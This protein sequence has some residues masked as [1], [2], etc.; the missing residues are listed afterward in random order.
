MI[1]DNLL[2]NGVYIEGQERIAHSTGVIHTLMRGWIVR[3]AS[4]GIYIKADDELEGTRI[5]LIETKTARIIQVRVS[6]WWQTINREIPEGS[7]VRHFKGGKYKLLGYGIDTSS[8]TDSNVAIY[9]SLDTGMLFTRDKLDFNSVVDK[10]THRNVEQ[11][12]RFEI[13]ADSSEV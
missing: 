13:I 8:P 3:V 12:Y 7:I 6:K 10:D 2:Q 4:E 1:T 5:A 11:H 9:Q